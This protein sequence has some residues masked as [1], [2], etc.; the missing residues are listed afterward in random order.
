MKRDKQIRMRVTQEEHELINSTA[1]ERNMNKTQY[2][3]SLVQK[4]T[5]P[6][7]HEQQIE[8]AILSNQIINNLLANPETPSIT[9]KLIRKD[10]KNYVGYT[11]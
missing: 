8:N 6:L 5:T 2:L 10:M 7:S 3:L 1:K 9:K 4:D 11:N